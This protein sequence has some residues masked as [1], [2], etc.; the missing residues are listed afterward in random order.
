LIFLLFFFNKMYNRFPN[1]AIFFDSS[2]YSHFLLFLTL[3]FLLSNISF[4]VFK[5]IFTFLFFDSFCSRLSTFCSDEF[6]L[7]FNFLYPL[8]HILFN[9]SVPFSGS[10]A[11]FNLIFFFPNKYQSIS[12]TNAF[13]TS[14]L[15]THKYPVPLGAPV[16]FFKN[17]LIYCIV[18]MKSYT[19]YCYKL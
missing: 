13:A 1:L 6:L 8:E 11:I 7:F 4:I 18:S 15:V 14:G 17:I 2:N 10:L 12:S 5:N 3:Q 19:D 9:P 16:Y